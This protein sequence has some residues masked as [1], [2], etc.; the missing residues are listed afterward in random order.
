MEPPSAVSLLVSNAPLLPSAEAPLLAGAALPALQLIPA[1]TGLPPQAAALLRLPAMAPE[2]IHAAASQLPLGALPVFPLA[3]AVAALPP[4]AAGLPMSRALEPQLPATAPAELAHAEAP[5]PAAAALPLLPVAPA[6][7]TLPE[8]ASARQSVTPAASFLLQ[9][10][11]RVPLLTEAAFQAP[12]TAPAEAINVAR[13][14]P[15]AM[16]PARPIAPVEAALPPQSTAMPPPTVQQLQLPVRVALAQQAAAPRPPTTA[17]APAQDSMAAAAPAVAHTPPLAGLPFLP[18]AWAAAAVPQRAIFPPGSLEVQL[19]SPAPA[20]VATP[21]VPAAAPVPPD[22]QLSDLVGALLGPSATASALPP[23]A[24]ALRFHAGLPPLPSGAERPK[25]AAAPAHADAQKAVEK[26][27]E[28]KVNAALAPKSLKAAAE[29]PVQGRAVVP[30]SGQT[31]LP[32]AAPPLPAAAPPLPAV[33]LPQ[34]LSALLS[35]A[36]AVPA[37]LP[38]PQDADNLKEASAAN[39][40][41]SA[42]AA[43]QSQPPEASAAGA[44]EAT[45]SEVLSA[46]LAPAATPSSAPAPA[47]EQ[48]SARPAAGGLQLLPALLPSLPVFLP[49]S[50]LASTE[51]ASSPPAAGLPRPPPLNFTSILQGLDMLGALTTAALAPVIGSPALAGGAPAASP[52]VSGIVT[53]ASNSSPASVTSTNAAMQAARDGKQPPARSPAPRSTLQ[54]WF[55]ALAALL[56]RSAAVAFM[57][58]DA[59][60]AMLLP[61]PMPTTG[62]SAPLAAPGPLPSILQGVRPVCFF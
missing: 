57:P 42:D 5:L 50:G 49:G 16:V 14:W 25:E 9:Q 58:A 40:A 22:A 13:P 48:E 4:H 27:Q 19:P 41:R 15:T 31:G 55:A 28:G 10:S 56:P 59:P 21:S 33:G 34:L 1:E 51:A 52:A 11:A 54:S 7:G 36:A 8:R 2:Q 45:L 29:P 38:Q 61:A 47:P 3:P 39:A 43:Q 23:S 53:A 35:P 17:K 32:T 46:L 60:T 18:M 6:A 44:P 24:T 30:P 12:A 62:V 26:P 37:P 20:A